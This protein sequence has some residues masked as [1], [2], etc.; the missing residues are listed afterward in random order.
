VF[1]GRLELAER[2]LEE[3]KLSPDRWLRAAVH[4]SAASYAE[5]EG[6]VPGMRASVDIA[7]TEFA[8]IGDR[9]GL[10]TTLLARAQL[11]TLDG[12]LDQAIADYTA[13]LESVAQL[14]SAEDDLYIHIRLADIYT[15]V[16][17]YDAAREEL[18]RLRDSRRGGRLSHERE[19]FGVAALAVLEWHSGHEA[20]ARDLALE[21]R[22][23]IGSRKK[24]SPLLGHVEAIIYSTT[25]T[26]AALSGDLVSAERDVLTAYPIAV[27]TADMPLVSGA[28]VA[29]AC[30][31]AVRGSAED[32][33]V[34]LGAA[35]AVRGSDDLTDL[36]STLLR[37][38]IQASLG[39]GFDEF[40]AQ[41]RSLPRDE[42][43]VRLNP[44]RLASTQHADPP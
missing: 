31:L 43:V 11:A 41:G 4:A 36:T 44:A 8:A 33:A 13:A 34:M 7:Y 3:A 40:Y 6:D 22:A 5:N 21:L 15:R 10:S 26:I 24:P 2:L 1:S 27:A 23:Q 35:A 42:A 14:G 39:G 32:A 18:V 28:G 37:K 9:W 20:L 12:D 30:W 19:L 17:D 16:G 38:R 29:I 25:A